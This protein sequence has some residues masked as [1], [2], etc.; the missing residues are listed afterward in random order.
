[1][2]QPASISAVSV[3]MPTFNE[4]GNIAALMHDVVENIRGSGV[5]SIE[6]VVVDDDSPD[7]TWEVAERTP[8]NGAEVRVIRRMADHGLTASIREGIQNAKHDVIVWLD[9]DFSHP[10]DRIPQLLFMLG[11]GF[12]VAVNSRY[13][14][15]GGED[16]SGKGGAVQLF[17]SHFLNWFVRFLLTASFSDYT[18]GFVAARKEVLQA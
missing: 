18:S 13:T 9:C 6:V 17:L 11:Q 14:V 2:F 7:R 1:M 16:R 5:A 10:P 15:G 3:V 8:T 4:A 12:D